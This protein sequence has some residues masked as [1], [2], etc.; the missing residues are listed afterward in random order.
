MRQLSLAFW[1]VVLSSGPAIGSFQKSRMRWCV[2]GAV[3]PDLVEKEV[4]ND[5]PLYSEFIGI[6]LV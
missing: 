2:T 1:F 5:V 3:S 6:E 4:L